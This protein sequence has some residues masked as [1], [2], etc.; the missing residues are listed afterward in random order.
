LAARDFRVASKGRMGNDV[1]L[2]EWA[3]GALGEKCS[4]RFAM[5][6][7]PIGL[8]MKKVGHC[9]R[10]H[11]AF[12]IARMLHGIVDR[13]QNWSS[14]DQA[15]HQAEPA[16]TVAEKVNDIG[17]AC[18]YLLAQSVDETKVSWAAM[19]RPGQKD[20]LHGRVDKV[21]VIAHLPIGGQKDNRA[22][23][24]DSVDVVD[25]VVD[26]ECLDTSDLHALVINLELGCSR[27]KYIQGSSWPPTCRNRPRHPHQ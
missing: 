27:Q 21:D 25:T 13:D 8:P 12:G 17:I 11:R 23:R 5:D 18:F 1:D 3:L 15:W 14:A 26:R 10:H 19:T 9:I 20:S 2:V 4:D 16:D 7:Q 6:H 24:C 22:K